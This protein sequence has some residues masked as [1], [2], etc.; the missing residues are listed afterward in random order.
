MRVFLCLF[1]CTVPVFAQLP[2]PLSNTNFD[3]DLLIEGEFEYSVSGWQVTGAA[4]VFNPTQVQYPE[5]NG[6]RQTVG[7][8]NDGSLFQVTNEP[9]IAGKDYTLTLEVGHRNDMASQAPFTIRFMAAGQVLAQTGGY[10]IPS[11]EW[12]DVTLTLTVSDAHPVGSLLEVHLVSTG[13]Q[14]HYDN[15]TLTRKASGNMVS[16]AILSDKTLHVPGHYPTI[17]AALDALDLRSISKDAIV[18]IQVA[19][20]IYTDYDTIEVNHPDGGNIK[21]LGNTNDPA[22]CTIYFKPGVNGLSVPPTR[23]LGHINGF[24]F[25][26]NDKAGNGLSCS[27]GGF[28]SAGSQM[29]IKNFHSAVYAKGGYIN[30][31]GVQVLNNHRGIVSQYGSVIEASS[32]I[33][34]GNDSHGFQAGIGGIIN[35]D[36]ASS[37]SNGSAGYSSWFGGTLKAWNSNSQ[38]NYHGY[39]STIFSVTSARNSQA[40]GNVE[41]YIAVE[42]SLV[43]Q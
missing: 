10:V 1:M 2:I 11:G 43:E 16:D 23:R 34:Q 29:T 5:G 26:G 28:I 18:T 3:E 38:N 30:C 27:W 36:N 9:L 6:S 12:R 19:D 17:Q 21:I 22:L 39:N 25:H 32:A 15:L 42:S 37:Q 8:T 14:T 13:N 33:A 40:S 41:N 7:F 31:S 35:A 4:G 24:A 20:G